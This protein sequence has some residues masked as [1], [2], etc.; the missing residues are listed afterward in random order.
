MHSDT[1]QK[2]LV[3]LASG[4][5]SNAEHLIRYFSGSGLAKVTCVVTDQPGAGVIVKAGKLGVPVRVITRRMATDGP[6]MLHLLEQETP[7]LILLAGYLRLIPEPVVRTYHDRIINIH[8]ALLPAYGGK[9]MYGA[10]VHQA[11]FDNREKETGITIHLVNERYDEGRILLQ[12]S[13]G[14]EPDDTPDS[15]A[16]KVHALEMEWYP[17]T[18]QEY[19]SA[20]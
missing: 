13:T 7:D 15:I 1:E 4:N 16:G 17:I 11:V 18:V 8:P 12:R 2:K 3:V 5:G 10:H 20:G 9:G 14:I 19:L 6:T